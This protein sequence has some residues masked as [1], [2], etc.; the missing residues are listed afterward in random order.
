MRHIDWTKRVEK[1]LA[2]HRS[3]S[4]GSVQRITPP[5]IFTVQLLFS[6]AGG[7]P[8]PG[9]GFI[10]NFPVTLPAKF[11]RVCKMTSNDPTAWP[12]NNIFMHFTPFTDATVGNPATGRLLGL[13]AQTDAFP[14]E[15]QS[16]F[17]W[18]K[19]KFACGIPTQIYLSADFQGTGTHTDNIAFFNDDVDVENVMRGL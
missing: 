1:Y 19:Y 6:A 18:R 3:V 16:G 15:L 8:T 9:T 2:E 5:N 7:F 13:G 12:I 17:Q 14:L 10:N 4:G 11:T